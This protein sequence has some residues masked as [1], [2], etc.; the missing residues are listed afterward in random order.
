MLAMT[1]RTEASSEAPRSARGRP[2][3]GAG[4]ALSL[5]AACGLVGCGEALSDEQIE[6]LDTLL[7]V[8]GRL[9]QSEGLAPDAAVRVALIWRLGDEVF[10]VGADEPA[11]RDSG[12]VYHY[13]LRLKE[14][15]NRDWLE[16]AQS[17]PAAQV[18]S[19]P[20]LERY[21]VGTLVVYQDL[22]QS[23]SLQRAETGSCQ[24]PDRLLGLEPRLAIWYVEASAE[25]GLGTSFQ[26]GKMDADCFPELGCAQSLVQA[27]TVE[28]G[29]RVFK[30]GLLDI[31]L[32]PGLV[33]GGCQSRE[34]LSQYGTCRK[35][36]KGLSQGFSTECPSHNAG[37]SPN[38]GRDAPVV[39]YQ[40]RH[41][42]LLRKLAKTGCCEQDLGQAPW[43]CNPGLL[44][45]PPGYA[46]CRDKCQ[47]SCDREELP[48]W[49]TIPAGTFVMGAPATETC[50]E[51][52]RP[53]Q[54]V[55]L[56]HAFA[57]GVTEVTQGQYQSVT[58]TNPSFYGPGAGIS[59]YDCGPDCPVETVSWDD[60]AAYCNALSRMNGLEPCY[61]C[62]PRSGRPACVEQPQY[63][64]SAFY[65]CRGYRLPTEAE[66][67]YAYRAGTKT[68]YYNGELTV[69]S[70]YDPDPRADQI[71]W[72]SYNVPYDRYGPQPA[73]KK[74]PN[75][76]GLYD[77]PG[78]V[79]EWTQDWR[80]YQ[81]GDWQPPFANAQDPYRSLPSDHL[82]K[83]PESS[84]SKH[85]R[86]GSYNSAAPTLSASLRR[87]VSKTSRSRLRGLRCVRSL[88]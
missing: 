88:F 5:L 7:L 42:D 45:C 52:I 65:T 37:C 53:E 41:H 30:A 85:I 70:D 46:C 61:T 78:N 13:E 27:E 75:A 18:Q 57:I 87:G 56:T 73:A 21:L 4:L 19:L 34:R 84:P 6:T 63:R 9:Q 60:A 8:S 26:L 15:P 51:I 3:A 35:L 28:F 2:G 20:G 67:E 76:W 36:R 24:A 82:Q 12:G 54:V 72:Y 66:W 11:R 69:C 22:D 59:A 81:V 25:P 68:A 40:P 62:T 39:V 10:A 23:R 71:G 31:A 50:L 74:L 16:P 14:V 32:D 79:D 47:K 80:V 29:R 43:L 17:L 44:D 58:G 55:T 86:G 33:S 38:T 77:M 48:R 64:D 83:H 1:S 49:A